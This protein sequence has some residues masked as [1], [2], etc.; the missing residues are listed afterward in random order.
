[1]DHANIAMTIRSA[2]LALDARERAVQQFD[3]PAPRQRTPRR[4]ETQGAHTAGTQEKKKPSNPEG[5]LG[6]I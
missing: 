2:H 4:P 3:R 5:L 1:M 6:F